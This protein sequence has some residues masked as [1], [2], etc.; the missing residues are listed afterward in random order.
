[1]LSYISLKVY[2]NFG[3]LPYGK[4]HT[5]LTSCIKT[6]SSSLY[7][8][9]KFIFF[10]LST[11]REAV[12]SRWQPLLLSVFGIGGRVSPTEKKPPHSVFC[13]LWIP[14][15]GWWLMVSDY[16]LFLIIPLCGHFPFQVQN[17]TCWFCIVKEQTEMDKNGVRG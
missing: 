7:W 2:T 12:K 5:L 11:W 1:M 13:G 8:Q 15:G 9:E 14:C 17:E 16:L 10:Q 3:T 6:A 4:T